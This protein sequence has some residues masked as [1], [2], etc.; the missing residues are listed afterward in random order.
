MP[1]A[2][3]NTPKTREDVETLKRQWAQDPIWD[4]EDT[5]GFA[6]YRTELHIYRL[7]ME[8]RWLQQRHNNLRA[9][10]RTYLDALEALK[11]VL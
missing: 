4:L 6:A 8:K 9:V 11:G 5:D 7:E 10:V 2:K 3:D 1:R